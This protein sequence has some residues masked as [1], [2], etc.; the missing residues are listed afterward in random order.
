MEFT[1]ADITENDLHQVVL[2][3]PGNGTQV[4]VLPEYG[5]M[6][7]AFTVKTKKGTHNIIDNYSSAG[8]IQTSLA[9]SYKSSKLSPFACRIAAGKYVYDGETFEFDNK[10]MDGSAIHGLLF[11]K[12]FRKTS[13]FC[14]EQKAS[15]VF[16]YHYKEE[17]NG[18]P[19]SYTC[20]IRYTLLPKNTLELQT[21][22]INLDDLPIP[23][24]DGWHPYFTLGGKADNWL[25][26]FNA[27]TMLEFDEK[28]LPTGKLLPSTAFLQPALLGQTQLDNCFVLNNYNGYAAC[29]LRNE[30]EGLQLNL[31]PDASY[32]YLQIYTPPH[33][34]SIAIENLSAAPN[35]FN[36][37]LGL[38]MLP[39]R[40]THTFT[41]YYQAECE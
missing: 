17:D 12:A 34:Q 23:M 19:F 36:N 27:S 32:P 40:H 30:A 2:T 10:F 16:K 13:S 37:G 7:H 39:P 24:S 21:T 35:A 6:L 11:N 20:E 41:V 38:L 15:V 26:Y 18:Y 33:R 5:A 4:I 14:D 22:I 31:F 29:T 1:I 28:L 9:N 25:L 8:E 3:A